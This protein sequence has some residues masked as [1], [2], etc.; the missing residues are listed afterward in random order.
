MYHFDHLS[1]ADI[2]CKSENG[3]AMP[4]DVCVR[5]IGVMPPVARVCHKSCDA[6]CRF[7]DWAEWSKCI[8]GCNG[9]R[10]RTRKLIEGRLKL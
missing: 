1:L 2:S 4:V 7:D 10:F 3:T 5:E 9:N 6:E 8:N